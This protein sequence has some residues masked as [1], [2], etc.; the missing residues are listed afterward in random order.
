MFGS[1]VAVVRPGEVRAFLDS[2]EVGALWGVGPKTREKLRGLG[3]T[4]VR[5][6]AG[7][8]Q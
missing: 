2:L 8:P 6:L 1:G 5:Q 4:T 3:I 7:M